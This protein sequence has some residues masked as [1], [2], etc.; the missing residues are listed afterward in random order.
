[1]ARL[2]TTEKAKDCIVYEGNV[3][4]DGY[5]RKTTNDRVFRCEQ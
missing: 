4:M 1:M 3:F 5:D 2:I